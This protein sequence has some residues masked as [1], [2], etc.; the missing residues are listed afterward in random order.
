MRRSFPAGERLRWLWRLP[1]AF[2]SYR[3]V[4]RLGRGNGSVHRI[5]HSDSP[6]DVRMAVTCMAVTCMAVTCMAVTCM[7]VTCMAVTC[8]A[9]T[10]MAVT[11]MAVTYLPRIYNVLH[12][13]GHAPA[14]A[15]RAL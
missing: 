5:R 13:L 4:R 15:F 9:V 10:S 2:A 7:A 3:F 14:T 11:S 1:C 8:M 6:A 12:F